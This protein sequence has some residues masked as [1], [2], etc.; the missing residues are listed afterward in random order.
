MTPAGGELRSLLQDLYI[1]DLSGAIYRAYTARLRDPGGRRILE[2]Y[3]RAEEFRAARIEQHLTK[4]GAT[5]TPS[6]RRVFRGAGRLYGFLTSRLGSRIM[7]RIALSASR[8]SA[9]RACAALGDA[10]RPDLL[11]L[12]T[13]KARNEGDLLEGL[14][15][16]LIDTRPRGR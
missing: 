2:E 5:A 14:R 11:F 15:Q 3:L 12:A 4:L 1:F 9:R 8:R 7:L 13:L 6:I 16:H 10:G